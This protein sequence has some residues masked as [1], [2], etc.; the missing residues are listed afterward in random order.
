MVAAINNGNIY[1]STDS[2]LSWTR[3]ATQFGAVS[4][5]GVAACGTNQ[6]VAVGDYVYVSTN[7]GVSW[8]VSLN[9]MSRNWEAVVCSE[10]GSRIL[11]ASTDDDIYVSTNRGQSWTPRAGVRSWWSLA[12]S[13]DTS[14]VV[15]VVQ[16]GLIYTS[17]A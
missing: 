2:G 9:D 10:D 17:D 4:W 8:T 6:L 14:H 11:A 16:R 12:A 13:V 15:A 1:V 5:T 7:N 3:Q